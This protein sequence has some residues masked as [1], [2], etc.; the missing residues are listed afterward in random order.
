MRS[1]AAAIPHSQ[2]VEI[3]AAG[4]MSPLENPEAV[5]T[6]LKEFLARLA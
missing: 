5:T 3:S 1:I 6:A 4:H 2:F